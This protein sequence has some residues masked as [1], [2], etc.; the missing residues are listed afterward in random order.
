MTN[1]IKLKK[2]GIKIFFLIP[3]FFGHFN[4][5]NTNILHPKISS[6]G[7]KIGRKLDI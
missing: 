1:I 2:N 5:F 6:F 7:R 3:F 4:L